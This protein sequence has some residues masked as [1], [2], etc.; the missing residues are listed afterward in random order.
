MLFVSQI[1][2]TGSSINP[3]RSLG[4]VVITNNWKDHWVSR[5]LPHADQTPEN[6]DERPLL[7]V[8]VIHQF[9]WLR[10]RQSSPDILQFWR[11]R[12]AS[13][14]FSSSWLSSSSSFSWGVR[15]VV[16]Y[17]A[18]LGVSRRSLIKENKDLR[19]QRSTFQKIIL[20]DALAHMALTEINTSNDT[21]NIHHTVW[22]IWLFIA[23]SADRII[24]LPFLTT[25]LIHF[26]LKGW[27]NVL[28]ELGGGRVNNRSVP[29]PDLLGCTNQRGDRCR[30]GVRAP[31]LWQEIPAN[32]VPGNGSGNAWQQCC[33]EQRHQQ[34]RSSAV[35]TTWPA[36]LQC[37]SFGDSL[38][39]FSVS[40]ILGS[41]VE[42]RD[43]ATDGS[44][45]VFVVLNVEYCGFVR[46]FVLF[47][48]W[49]SC[50][51]LSVC[52]GVE[53]KSVLMLLTLVLLL[54][55]SP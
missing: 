50:H 12:I 26:S 7:V 44:P 42:T 4:P 3:A 24:I 51:F 17:A 35:E 30:L 53:R 20:G 38:D 25:S 19:F 14:P 45:L 9:Y 36:N 28:F 21:R 52:Q 22:R 33:P 11:H 34:K 16:R 31:V 43:P 40:A 18:C 5:N 23:Y 47:F 55:S 39:N 6:S 41:P 13:P 37:S 32:S 49:S 27:E 48:R 29:S 1:P 10:R 54:W 8:L 2:F 46:S 15:Y